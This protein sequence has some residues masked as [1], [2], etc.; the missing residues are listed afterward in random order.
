MIREENGCKDFGADYDAQIMDTDFERDVYIQNGLR[1]VLKLPLMSEIT[2]SNNI[3]LNAHYT[4]AVKNAAICQICSNQTYGELSKISNE[5]WQTHQIYVVFSRLG[6]LLLLV[7]AFTACYNFYIYCMIYKDV[8]SAYLQV[9][10]LN[11]CAFS[12]ALGHFLGVGVLTVIL[13]LQISGNIH[14][15]DDFANAKCFINNNVNEAIQELHKDVLPTTLKMTINSGLT[16]IIVIISITIFVIAN[17]ILSG[18]K[19]GE[20]SRNE[21]SQ[22]LRVREVELQAEVDNKQENKEED[23]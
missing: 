23:E 13:H 2:E 4:K 6:V 11:M 8:E 14:S 19:K 21:E 15:L 7:M 18:I 3:T 5:L 16:V 1:E 22:P 20:S 9:M 12:Y 17:Y 10:K